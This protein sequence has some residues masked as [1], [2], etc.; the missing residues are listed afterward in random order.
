MKQR[1]G[2]KHEHGLRS[3]MTVLLAFTVVAFGHMLPVAGETEKSGN[4]TVSNVNA[5]QR[6]DGT[7]LVDIYYD[8]SGAAG[9][10]MISLVFSNDNGVTWNVIPSSSML[11]GAVGAGVTNG[12][13]K[14]IVWDAGR[15]RADVYW[16]ET[17]A[18][19]R[20]TETGTTT[21]FMLPG[22]MPLEMVRIPAGSFVM[23]TGYDPDWGYS[24]EA[25]P[26]NVTIDYEFYIGKFP[27]TQ[28]QWFN[29]MG[30]F[31]SGQS[32]VGVNHPVHYVSW[33]DAQAFINQLNTLGIG[34]FRLPSESEWEYA[35]RAGSNTRWYFGDDPESLGDYA[36]YTANNSP[37][38]SKAVGQKLPN[39]FG[40]YDMHGNVWEWVQD[41]YNSNYEGAPSDGSAWEEGTSSTNR[42][43]RGGAYNSSARN[44]R[45]AARSYHNPGSRA[46]GNGL[47]LVRTP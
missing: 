43:R 17:R 4:P 41:R 25:P 16:P 33:N 20:A 34:T 2:M 3:T 9:P 31:P 23:G 7:G 8:L 13:G 35:C 26:R 36:W 18:R 15:D 27:V 1:Y 5:S 29:V 47:R 14:H 19:I 39:A 21:T 46:Y 6:D 38:G 37:S 32:P 44:C 11:W 10:V 12:N 22:E 28:Q 42:V 40:L 30:S 45:S 24:D